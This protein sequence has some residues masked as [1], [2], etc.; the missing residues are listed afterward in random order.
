MVVYVYNILAQ[1]KNNKHKKYYLRKK[2]WIWENIYCK[3]C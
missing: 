2:E 3:C 1:L